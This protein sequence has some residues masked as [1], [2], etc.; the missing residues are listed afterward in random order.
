MAIFLILSGFGLT[1][2]YLKT[3]TQCFVRK[4]VDK[5]LLPYMLITAIWFIWDAKRYHRYF[6][7]IIVLKTI[8]GLKTISPVDLSMWYITYLIIW[9]IIFYLIFSLPQKNI[10]KVIMIFLCALLFWDRKIG[11]YFSVDSGANLYFP[12][13]S[14]GVILGFSYNY[15]LRIRKKY[16]NL[17]LTAILLLSFG[18]YTYF[19]K[20][21]AMHNYLF[22]AFAIF[23]FAIF[24][25]SACSLIPYLS[26][27]RPLT[28]I[29]RI[30]YEMYLVEFHCIWIYYQWPSINHWLRL[31][32]TVMI[33]CG[34]STAFHY[35]IFFT[36]KMSKKVLISINSLTDRFTSFR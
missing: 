29:G 33:I 25:I 26:K 19:I 16:L 23:C 30:S 9:Y 11:N 22:Y 32:L 13:F 17:I 2:S 6:S 3:G 5:V 8:I 20:H 4:R 24:T 10:I 27:L 35:A 15:I 31:L 34:I 14:F 1:L 7:P 12:E 28:F 36:E 21:M 18:L